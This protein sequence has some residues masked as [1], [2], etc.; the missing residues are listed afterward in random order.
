M[1][2]IRD[3]CGEGMQLILYMTHP[4]TE[5]L[6]PF[7]RYAI[8]VQGCNKRC[9]GCISP[10]AQSLDGGIVV[11]VADLAAEILFVP[12]IEGITV[13]G[14]EPF[15]QQRALATLVDLLRDKRDM[16]V[17]VYTGI[18][19]EEIKETPLAQR[20]DLIIDGEYIEELND[21]KS[22]RGSSNQKAICVTD[23]YQRFA[24]HHYG[25]SGRKVEFCI[26][27]GSVNMVGIP[28]RSI[29]MEIG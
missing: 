4:T 29:A 19:Y 28:S 25:V 22:M 13:S 20:C 16:G 27:S 6:G 11:D 5:A 1:K 8:W 21:D 7:K 24:E 17:I 26:D 3:V 10:D 12:D 14:G 15:L 2:T 23:R 9:K 18:L